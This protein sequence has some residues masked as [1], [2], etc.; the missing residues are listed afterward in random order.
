MKI[1][2]MFPG[3]GAQ[4]VGMGEDFFKEYQE[5][6]EVYQKASEIVGKD[7][8]KMCFEGSLEKLSNTM[9]TQ[10]AISTTS[11]AILNIIKSYGITSE[12]DAGLSLGEY[13]AL[14]NSKVISLENGLKLLER[15]SYFMANKV[16]NKKYSMI[17]VIGLEASKIEELCKL[18]NENGEFVVPANY[19]YSG[20]I[21][22]TGEEKAI[23]NITPKLQ[24]IGA[25]RVIKLNTS[26]P[27]HTQK[28]AEASK[29]YQ[30]ELEKVDFEIQENRV[31][32][33]ID[34]SF[35]TKNDDITKILANHIISP[36]RFDKTIQTMQ[37]EGIDTYIEIGP[38]KALSGFVKKEDK[39]AK[40]FS[41]QKVEDLKKLLQ[42]LKIEKSNASL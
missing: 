24:E 2:F 21:V 5:A 16:P 42:E 10:I 8:A 9:N 36:V 27:F 33:N 34:G 30:K 6:R 4:F 31:I 29:C 7:I 37:K 11:L 25:K 18:A 19:N 23:E 22:V 20:Q 38:G 1:A 40:V 12:I 35:Y 39:E 13:V 14:I 41:I 15:R 17:A 26:G 28:L 3:Q 32:K